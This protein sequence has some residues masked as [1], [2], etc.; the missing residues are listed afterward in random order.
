MFI[1]SYF[2]FILGVLENNINTIK[3]YPTSTVLNNS[4]STVVSGGPPNPLVTPVSPSLRSGSYGPTWPSRTWTWPP[5][6]TPPCSCTTCGTNP[7]APSRRWTACRPRGPQSPAGRPTPGGPAEPQ[8][9]A[10]NTQ[11]PTYSLKVP[12]MSG[13]QEV[14][15]CVKTL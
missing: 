7:T 14:C 9:T 5:S 1:S 4:K 13:F 11:S 15:V 12:T 3:S 6:G 2:I 10:G 8:V